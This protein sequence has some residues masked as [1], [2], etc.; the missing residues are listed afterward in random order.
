MVWLGHF[1]SGRASGDT[2]SAPT[3][4]R[5]CKTRSRPFSGGVGAR[6]FPCELGWYA[7]ATVRLDIPASPAGRPSE[8]SIQA[9]EELIGLLLETHPEQ[10]RPAALDR[11]SRYKVMVDASMR[12]EA[13]AFFAFEKRKR[14]LDAG[15]P[16]AVATTIVRAHLESLDGNGSP[17]PTPS[18]VP[19]ELV[20]VGAEA[21]GLIVERAPQEVWVRPRHL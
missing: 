12:R 5:R 10:A 14:G 1:D 16:V 19:E 9:Y 4:P 3:L 8:K 21:T 20:D 11:T 18:P 13:L 17:G 2:Q 7:A 15:A 6:G